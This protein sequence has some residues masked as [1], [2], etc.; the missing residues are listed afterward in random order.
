MA[1]KAVSNRKGRQERKGKRG[2]GKGQTARRLLIVCLWSFPWFGR[3]L[4]SW[5]SLRLDAGATYGN[6]RLWITF[7]SQFG[8]VFLGDFWKA[9]GPG[10]GIRECDGRGGNVK[11][12]KREFA[13][14]C[15]F[16]AGIDRFLPAFAGRI[17]TQRSQR[18]PVSSARRDLAEGGPPRPPGLAACRARGRTQRNTGM[19]GTRRR[20][21][22]GGQAAKTAQPSTQRSR[23]T[24]REGREQQTANG[25]R[26]CPKGT[27][28][29][30]GPFDS[31]RFAQDKGR[32]S[33]N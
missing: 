30:E 12:G 16:F 3:S 23:R 20:R 32:K 19:G 9:T 13:L 27:E 26:Q 7:W 11:M 1:G 5:R 31:L 10:A 8:G 28:D 6:R 21:G 15:S 25:K 18:A 29:G 24:Q 22:Y 33:E 4:R 14:F 17:S 2:V